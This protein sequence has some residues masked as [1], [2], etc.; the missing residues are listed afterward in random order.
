M[1]MG[2]GIS[3]A[4]AELWQAYDPD[5]Y[6]DNFIEIENGYYYFYTLPDWAWDPDVGPFYI[7]ENTGAI[8]SASLRP[9][10]QGELI[11]NLVE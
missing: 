10:Q 1:P 3:Q 8:Y 9:S 11:G 5:D 7:D 6:N 2:W 4:A